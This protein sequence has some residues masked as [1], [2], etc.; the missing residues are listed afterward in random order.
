MTCII[1]FWTS[2]SQRIL[3]PA[4]VCKE[5]KHPYSVPMYTYLKPKSLN[6][7]VNMAHNYNKMSLEILNLSKSLKII[8]K[9]KELSFNTYVRLIPYIF[10][11][12]ILGWSRTRIMAISLAADS[13]RD[14]VVSSF[15]KHLIARTSLVS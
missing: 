5:S 10:T 13:Y 12:I 6:L 9:H 4:Y 3:I 11:E 7:T 15:L 2:S 1:S 8:H 14:L